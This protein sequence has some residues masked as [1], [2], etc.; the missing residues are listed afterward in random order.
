MERYS[1]CRGCGIRMI[2]FRKKGKQEGAEA[3]GFMQEIER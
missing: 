2:E 1:I 3:G